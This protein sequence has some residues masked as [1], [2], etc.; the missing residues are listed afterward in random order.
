[1]KQVFYSSDYGIEKD[2]K[3]DVTRKLQQL[4]DDAG[5]RKGK[6]VITKGVY[7]TGSLFLRSDMEF[8]LEEGAVL[9]GS[10]EEEAYPLMQTR[11]AGIEMEW[12]GGLLN[13]IDCENITISGEG[14]LDGQGEIWWE[15]FWGKDRRGG[16]C[17]EYE[18]KGIRWAV[19]YDCIRPR[20]VQIRNCR[21][22]VC[23]DFHLTR[24]GF[25]NLHVCYCQ[26][27]WISGVRITN[28]QGPSTD[29]I[30]IDSCRDVLVEKCDISCNDDNIVI[31]AGMNADG[32][33][34]NRIC[35]RV[36]VRD[37]MLR[38]GMGLAFGS[39]MAGGID[40]VH[41][42]DI[43]FRGTDNGVYV[44]SAKIRG[45]FL[46][47][48]QIENLDMVNVG[49][50]INLNIN[51]FPDFSYPEIPADFQ[52]EIPQRWKL[53]TERVPEGKGMPQIR[54]MKI[55]HLNSVYEEG[56]T[57]KSVGFFIQAYEENPIQNIRLEDVRMTVKE[58][59]T[60]GQVKNLKM[61]DVEVNVRS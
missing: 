12:M 50:T 20:L 2:G 13:A 11:A 56:Y 26:N 49:Y 17:R 6:A 31:K 8:C 15:K 45:G 35:E 4:I 22:V 55:R 21:N 41:L 5:S 19:D 36:E 1:M 38:E 52:G 46:D 10:Q 37:C 59:G 51:W 23:R 60:I 16:M 28:A 40:Q 39:D 14:T 32:M 44:K 7:L 9:L 3:T 43:Q 27:V 18:K 57:G 53:L 30:D 61:T 47:H 58:F 54:G 29:G 34:V 24:S 42:H 25:W 48:I 33:R